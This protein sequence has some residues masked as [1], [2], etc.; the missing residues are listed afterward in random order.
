[1]SIR[2][3]RHATGRLRIGAARQRYRPRSR[4]Q[5]IVEL[6]LI[7]P[8]LLLLLA[9]ALDLGRLFY[10]QIT[11]ANASRE[12][13]IEAAL[14]P[15]SFSAGAGCDAATNRVM[16]RVVN[17][18]Q[19]SFV[20]V[21]PADVALSC[22]PASCAKAIGS[23]VTVTVTGHFR[24]ITPILAVFTGGQDITFASSAEAQINTP[25]VV[26]AGGG[27]PTPTPTLAPTPT[28]TLA[29]GATPTPTPAPTGGPTI[30]PLCS[31]P[32]ASFTWTNPANKRIDFTDT[33]TNMATAGC[34]N[35]WSWNFGDGAGTSA[36]QN[37]TYTYQTGSRRDVTLTVSNS[38]GSSSRTIEVRP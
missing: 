15:A 29:P 4:G 28:L 33:S 10:S 31:A 1:M 34:I 30:P 18:T 12:G 23:T 11:V 22:S 16:C 38:A 2:L 24:L 27:G 35:V 14:N 21:A 19:S 3:W 9:A 7:L 25:P 8:I 36:A 17:E 13:A 6:A 37:P 32:V 20:S 5:A 26:T